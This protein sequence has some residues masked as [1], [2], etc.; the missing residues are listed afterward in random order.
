MYIRMLKPLEN[1]KEKE[2]LK[3]KSAVST[4]C[5]YLSDVIVSGVIAEPD[6]DVTIR[7]IVDVNRPVAR[8]H[9]APRKQSFLYSKGSLK[10]SLRVYNRTFTFITL[11]L[12]IVI[13]VVGG[14]F[15]IRLPERKSIIG[16]SS[17]PLIA[18]ISFRNSLFLSVLRES[19]AN[20]FGIN[21]GLCPC[22]MAETI[23]NNNKQLIRCMEVLH[24][25]IIRDEG[26]YVLPGYATYDLST[27]AKRTFLAGKRLVTYIFLFADFWAS[28]IYY[29]DAYTVNLELD[30]NFKVF[31]DP[32]YLYIFTFYRSWPS[33]SW[34][35][36][37]ADIFVNIYTL[38][39]FSSKVIVL[40]I[41]SHDKYQSI[42]LIG[43][44]H[45]EKASFGNRSILVHYRSYWR[46]W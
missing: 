3:F 32:V 14:L 27:F 24:N 28:R 8:K 16:T 2:E 6:N 42:I 26:G 20:I 38:V 1:R 15:N 17:E 4:N 13:C 37:P 39:Y 5:P 45:A 44:T 31:F 46:E 35:T 40:I 29:F 19:S 43:L 18:T 10:S 33:C 30:D 36:Y 22:M 23:W 34:A 12:A 41:I 25:T 9:Y 11:I 7:D 21:E